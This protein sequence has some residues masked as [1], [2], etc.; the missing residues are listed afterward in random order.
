MKIIKANKFFSSSRTGII[1]GLSKNVINSILSIKGSRVKS[2]DS[3]VTVE[4]R[5]HAEGVPC[6]IWDYKGSAKENQYSVYMPAV[7]GQ[8]LFGSNFT[9]DP[10]NRD[11]PDYRTH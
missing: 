5:F 9:A 4:W 2:Y 10:D 8:S 1:T 6:A 3:K 7:I 11:D